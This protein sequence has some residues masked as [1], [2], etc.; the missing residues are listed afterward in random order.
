MELSSKSQ[1][2]DEFEYRKQIYKSLLEI[3]KS[4]SVDRCDE[5]VRLSLKEDPEFLQK[6][7]NSYMRYGVAL[8]WVAPA[9]SFGK[10]GELHVL[11]VHLSIPQP[12]KEGFPLGY[13]DVYKEENGFRSSPVKIPAQDVISIR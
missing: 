7:V 11:P 9:I 8:I 4:C 10:I 12:A 5:L 6:I 2:F 1:N 3:D 13:F